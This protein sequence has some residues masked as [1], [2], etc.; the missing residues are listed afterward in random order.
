M[1]AGADP[2]AA[3]SPSG[4]IHRVVSIRFRGGKPAPR[5][6]TGSPGPSSVD[7]VSAGVVSD[8]EAADDDL[9][10]FARALAPGGVRVA[11]PPVPTGIVHRGKAAHRL[12]D[13]TTARCVLVTAPAGYGKTTLLASLA[14]G[15]ERPC[16][17]LTL[18]RADNDPTSLLARVLLGLD[19]VER[20]PDVAFEQIVV[21]DASL[22][23]VRLP[24][25][26]DVLATRSP[27]VLVLDDAHLLDA[28]Q[29]CAVVRTL[30]EHVP[31]S[32][33]VAIATRDAS[34]L[35]LARARAGGSV[36][37]L[38][39][40]DLTMSATEGAQL[41]RGA[42]LSLVDEEAEALVELTEG[43]PAA[44]YLCA[45]A[46]R[47]AAPGSIASFG[48]GDRA[49][50]QYLA[51]EV[52]GSVAEDRLD[53]MLRTSV[54]DRLSGP[55]CDHVL[56]VSG[57]AA[58]L[59]SLADANRLVVPMDR[60][61][62][63]YRYHHLFQDLLVAELARRDPGAI[64]DLHVRAGTWLE[65]AG[66]A[67]EA[68][69]HAHAG[70]DR[71]RAV[72]LVWHHAPFFIATG[73]DDTVA[74]WLAPFPP[75]E[76]V[77]TPA[78]SVMAAWRAFAAGDTEEMSAWLASLSDSSEERLPSG[79]PVQ[80]A[81]ALLR[82]LEG[83]DSAQMRADAALAYR[84]DVPESPF[85]PV[86]ALLEGVAA[87]LLG[88][89]NGARASFERALP[90]GEL[91]T[92]SV[93][94]HALAF[95]ALMADDEGR[96]DEAA[97][98]AARSLDKAYEIHFTERPQGCIPFSVGALVAAHE[99][100]T[101]DA[102]ELAKHAEFLLLG[103]RG[104]GPWISVEFRIQ[105]AR[106][107]LALGESAEA[108]RLLAVAER[109]VVDHPGLG[110]LPGRLEQLRHV[111]DA[112]GMPLGLHATPLTAAELRVLRYLP[113]HL[114]FAQIADELFV[115]RNTVKT[116]AIAIY[117]KLEVSSRGEAVERARALG[118]IEG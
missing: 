106:V 53:F 64:R 94:M 102:R 44:L 21:S 46:L 81:V 49:I 75:G 66:D 34:R 88:D 84:E 103:L 71:E 31:D 22:E 60:A 105:L 1:L 112:A 4:P 68:M 97:V 110:S 47:D 14:E 83:R 77:S 72:A 59:D 26:V 74:R 80:A 95:Q 40:A 38:A 20:V 25:L 96:I 51:D 98:L 43:W 56:G 9:R 13:G 67:D 100:R 62:E 11:A 27:F 45:L 76:I 117:R 90:L 65:A 28:P 57:S 23:E 104:F 16:A 12:G 87:R 6:C 15:D 108:R 35:G 19:G 55:L 86:A 115:S 85:R 58:M 24:R 3:V 63:W 37:D 39:T 89:A 70:G 48:G 42:G 36:L 91:L 73:R 8:P 92:P 10:A 82:A 17:W 29:A 18:G 109:V 118:L 33:R 50:A 116:Q 69:R 7:E 79:A 32:S 114:S 54:L 2:Q 78:L 30:V 5:L 99:G 113:T 93:A 107:A 101:N 41:L 61:G 111:A 52:L